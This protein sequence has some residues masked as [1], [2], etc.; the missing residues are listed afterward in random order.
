[1]TVYGKL[2][3][4]A[5]PAVWLLTEGDA[6]VWDVEENRRQQVRQARGKRRAVERAMQQKLTRRARATGT[7]TGARSSTAEANEEWRAKGANSEEI[8]RVWTDGACEHN[9]S[10]LGSLLRRR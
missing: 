10:R 9:G 6:A 8:C 3:E 7:L 1:M 5:V 2:K 4:T